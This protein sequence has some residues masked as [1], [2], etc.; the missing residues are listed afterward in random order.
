[1]GDKGEI[2][3]ET[4]AAI[5]LRAE[6]NKDAVAS[7]K[8]LGSSAYS[9]LIAL[10]DLDTRPSNASIPLRVDNSSNRDKAET[11]SSKGR[12]PNKIN[13]GEMLSRDAF[14]AVEEP[15]AML[16]ARD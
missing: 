15:V 1:M 10:E 8:S 14:S 11:T 6:T 9:K 3:V 13:R 16:I 12:I 7:S 4:K 2:T 5:L